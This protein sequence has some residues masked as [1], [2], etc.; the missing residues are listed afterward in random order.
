MSKLLSKKRTERE[1]AHCAAETDVCYSKSLQEPNLT[2]L[3]REYYLPDRVTFLRTA[4]K[5][6]KRTTIKK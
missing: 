2:V 5:M 1:I 3:E 6:V 4:P